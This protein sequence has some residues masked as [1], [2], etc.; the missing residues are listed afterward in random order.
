M[1]TFVTRTAMAGGFALVNIIGAAAFFAAGKVALYIDPAA[2]GS[3]LS[4]FMV[5]IIGVAVAVGSAFPIF[6]RGVPWA[7][8][9]LER[10]FPQRPPEHLIS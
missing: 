6:G 4:A 2:N 9:R 1:R 7:A 10:A 8:S 3:H 5:A